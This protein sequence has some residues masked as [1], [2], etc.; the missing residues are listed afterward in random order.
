MPDSTS[1]RTS[2]AHFRGRP[3]EHGLRSKQ[4]R[5]LIA[6]RAAEIEAELLSAGHLDQRTHAIARAEVARVW[7]LIELAED[8]IDKRGVTTGSGAT[9]NI[10]SL[11][12]SLSRELR[13]WLVQLGLTPKAQAEVVAA[14]RDVSRPDFHESYQRKLAELRAANG[15]G[16]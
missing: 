4:M 6:E 13:A 16:E 2:D 1:D 3:V 14:L 9:R 5:P 8:S 11:R 15:G 7:A 12:I 10:V